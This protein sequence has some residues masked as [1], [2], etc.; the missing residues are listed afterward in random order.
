[1]GSQEKYAALV[2]EGFNAE[3]IYVQLKSDGIAFA[4]RIRI[5]RELFGLNL[6]EA[7]EITIKVDT[8]FKSIDEY[9]ESLIEP[10]KEFLD[11]M[12]RDV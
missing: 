2:S 1:M 7:K 5:L 12:E 3:Q 6:I 11:E 8:E 4:D 10:L 9:Q